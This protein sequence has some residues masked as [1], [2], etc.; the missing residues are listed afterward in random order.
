M[1]AI[2]RNMD[3]ALRLGPLMRSVS[4]SFHCV[5]E[6][7]LAAATSR[8]KTKEVPPLTLYLCVYPVRFSSDQIES[9]QIGSDQTR[10]RAQQVFVCRH[11]SIE[12]ADIACAGPLIWILRA[13][14]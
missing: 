3:V 7:L 6:R 9:A 12:P 4:G 13:L 1:E 14:S 10:A 8:P 5:C 2:N 11:S